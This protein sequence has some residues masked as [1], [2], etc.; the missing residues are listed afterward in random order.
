M[1]IKDQYDMI[2]PEKEYS[3]LEYETFYDSIGQIFKMSLIENQLFHEVK[4]SL[5]AYFLEISQN[6]YMEDK[7][8]DSD[9][10]I[11]G[12]ERVKGKKYCEIFQILIIFRNI[13]IQI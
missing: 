3:L 1:L 2:T 10:M 12:L 5:P 13:L 8:I 9:L 11:L 6:S 4:S 7:E